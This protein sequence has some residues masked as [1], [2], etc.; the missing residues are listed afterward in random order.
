[1][2]LE[3]RVRTAVERALRAQAQT[4]D[5]QLWVPVGVSA[6]HIHLG[7]A[8]VERLF[9]A[10]HAL[11]PVRE[12]QPGQFAA[13]EAVTLVGPRGSIAGV[14]VLGPAR[15]RTQVEISASDGFMLG[16]HPPVRLS[17]NV[18]GTPG[19]AVVGPRG[20][21]FLEDGVIVAKRHLH[22][23]PSAAAAWGL[24]H[25]QVVRAEVVGGERALV[26]G[27]VVVRVGAEFRLELHLDTDEANASGL[28]TGDLCRV[29]KAC[30]SGRG[31]HG[32]GQ[33]PSG[34]DVEPA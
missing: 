24:V 11:H 17:G 34:A 7:G 26:L 29:L 30:I 32:V 33:S 23:P 27:E 28:R 8:D 9:G 21:L 16:V 14:R 22:M 18:Q 5:G 4:P 3:A 6:R 2:E 1:M 19:I 13:E 10:G 20:A 12:L 15:G 31:H 25:G